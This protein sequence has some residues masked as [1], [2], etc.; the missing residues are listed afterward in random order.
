MLVVLWHVTVST[1]A[2]DTEWLHWKFT[3]FRREFC[4]EDCYEQL[5]CAWRCH[6]LYYALLHSQVE[7]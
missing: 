4:T 6:G 1:W 2:A 5:E 3:T 7:W